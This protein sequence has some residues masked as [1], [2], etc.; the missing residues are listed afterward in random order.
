MEGAGPM[1]I[2][3]IPKEPKGAGEEPENDDEKKDKKNGKKRGKSI[4]EILDQMARDQGKRKGRGTGVEGQAAA[5]ADPDGMQASP[6]GKG[7]TL[8]EMAKGDWKDYANKRIEAAGI[9][10]YVARILRH[11]KERQVEEKLQR[12]D[13]HSIWPEGN[14]LNRLDFDAYRN[15]IEKTLTDENIKEEDRRFW[16]LDKNILISS[17]V[18]L[19]IMID[20]SSSMYGEYYRGNHDATALEIALFCAMIFYEAGKDVGMNVTV[21]MWGSNDPVIIARPGDNAQLI[22]E[23]FIKARAGLDCGTDMVPSIRSGLDVLAQQKKSIPEFAGFA[24]FL[25]F[26]DGDIS[27]REKQN[28]QFQLF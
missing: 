19:V 15:Y 7:R 21:G 28:R 18:D 10:A 3:K 16:E 1:P 11:V 5:D 22:Q 23:N 12:S 4:G 8:E 14:E 13:T 17:S 25:Y 27:G 9:I 6:G 24:H 2:H 26:S 20:G